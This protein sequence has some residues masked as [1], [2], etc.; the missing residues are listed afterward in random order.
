MGLKSK[1]FHPTP[2]RFTSLYQSSKKNQ[3]VLDDVRSSNTFQNHL[4]NSEGSV[5]IESRLSE[6]STM[7]SSLGLDPGESSIGHQDVGE[8]YEEDRNYKKRLCE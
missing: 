5:S 7:S 6:E 3:R 4:S 2:D 8:E 1:L